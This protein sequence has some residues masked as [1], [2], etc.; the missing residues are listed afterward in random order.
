MIRLKYKQVTDGNLIQ[1]LQKLVRTPLNTQVAY[2]VKKIADAYSKA[3]EQI[4]KEYQEQVV[5]KFAEKDEKGVIIPDAE[6]LGGFKINETDT[7]EFVAIHEAFGMKDF[8]IER[9]PL[10]VGDLGD[11]KFSA[12]ELTTL[13][14]FVSEDRIIGGNVV[15]MH[16]GGSA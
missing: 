11:V 5:E 8:V 12:L 1:A 4:G 15:P 3:R 10:W 6:S 14:P 16:L 13:E 7:T 2:R 9:D